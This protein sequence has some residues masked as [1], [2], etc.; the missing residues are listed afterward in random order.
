MEWA[1]TLLTGAAIYLLVVM[2]KATAILAVAWLL[3]ASAP[4]SSAAVRH[5][6][7]ATALVLV[8]LLPLAT[9]SLPP[10]AVHLPAFVREGAQ[11]STPQPA[12]VATSGATATADVAVSTSESG[13]SVLPSSDGAA[14]SDPSPL[15]RWPLLLLV[16]WVAGTAARAAWLGVQLRRVRRMV[17]EASPVTQLSPP[18]RAARRAAA[19]LGVGGSFSL[20]ESAR[21]P[22]PVTCGLF[23]PV[24]LI[25]ERSRTWPE[26]RLRVVLLH[27]LAHVRRRDYLSSLLAELVCTVYWPIPLVWAARA[28]M[29]V[30]QEQASDDLVLAAG[31][32]PLEY[33]DQ[34][35]A[36]ARS[37]RPRDAALAGV[38]EMARP[39]GLRY[40][41]KTIL[42]TRTRRVPLVSL[43]GLASL[44][45]L[46]LCA[47][48]LA[49]LRPAEDGGVS[50]EPATAL[51]TDAVAAETPTQELSVSAPAEPVYLWIEAEHGVLLGGL[52][53]A[54]DLEA[55][56]GQFVEQ[57]RERGGGEVRLSLHL[58]RAGDYRL[59]IRTALAEEDSPPR[60]SLDGATRLA[61]DGAEVIDASGWRWS[62]AEMAED[63]P[64]RLGAGVHTLSIQSEAPGGRIDRVLVTTD[65]SYLPSGTGAAPR[66]FAPIYRWVEMVPGPLS[67]PLELEVE[68]P[69]AGQY[70]V[71]GR[72]RGA[73]VDANSFFLSVD[74]GPEVIWDAPRQVLDEE[75]GR[76]VWD[77][78]SAR[79]MNGREVDPLLFDLDAGKHSIRLTPREPSTG[80]GGLLVTNDLAFR[81]QGRPP[82]SPPVDIWLEPESASPGDALRVQAADGRREGYLEAVRD[83]PDRSEPDGQVPATLVFT[84]PSPGIYTLWARTVARSQSED[85]FWIRV[86][87]G[88][89]MRWNGIPTSSEWRWSAV[90]DGDEGEAPIQLALPAG[91]N[92]IEIARREGGARI[93]RLLVTNDEH[94]SPVARLAE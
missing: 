41:V 2:L 47:A 54:E 18:A 35:L 62:R 45:A 51:E 42:D 25:P 44:S 13:S 89:W 66:D 24:I 53:T 22:T 6:I 8:G 82:G 29:H 79:D 48:P 72:V 32:P 5:G 38:L 86:N 50:L 73:S 20:R 9:S 70:V 26:E 1:G 65:A 4:K 30:E 81:P 34:L 56:A 14:A 40:R 90:H 31:T 76:W 37:L 91:E 74:D 3:A 78:A 87:G 21:V 60:L 67:E 27:E 61:L 59:W 52:A 93:E 55:S 33:A 12:S 16:L 71:W 80:I 17:A 83:G 94:A 84:L 85:S 15:N 75:E 46:L 43:Q 63:G 92:R 11:G 28:A 10:L 36:V 39:A 77:P 58:P 19:T 68:V 49:A 7:W 57:A 88:R 69:A 64:V 23:R